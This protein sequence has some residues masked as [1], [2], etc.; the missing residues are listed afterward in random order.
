MGGRRRS[1]WAH[2]A[3]GDLRG[4]FRPRRQGLPAHHLAA[5][6]TVG[7]RPARPRRRDHPRLARPTDRFVDLTA[8]VADMPRAEIA[9]CSAGPTGRAVLAWRQRPGRA[10]AFTPGPGS[11]P[12]C[13]T[14][15]ST[16][17]PASSPP[18]GSTSGPGPTPPP[19]RSPPTSPNWKPARPLRPGRAAPP[20]P[21]PR[22][23]PLGGGCLPRRAPRRPPR[24]RRGRPPGREPRRGRRTGTPGAHRRTPGPRPK[25]NPPSRIVPL[26]SWRVARGFPRTRGHTRAP[27][28][29]GQL[30]RLGRQAPPDPCPWGAN[31]GCR[32]AGPRAAVRCSR[33]AG[34]RRAGRWAGG[35]P[36][37]R[38]GERTR[39][40]RCHCCFPF[41][42]GS[43]HNSVVHSI[44]RHRLGLAVCHL[45]WHA[46]PE[47]PA[48]LRAPPV[49]LRRTPAAH[50]A[51]G[52]VR[53]PVTS[54]SP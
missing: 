20:L 32:A 19:G 40:T 16:S 36:S 43:G 33:T 24:R 47:P 54:A 3:G 27:Y 22:L 23:L 8:A 12:I 45:E 49:V 5:R 38:Y 11:H 15:I 42:A 17:I 46:P 48:A 53:G 10:V 44:T 21:P 41:A 31:R 7:R 39:I 52:P 29:G 26:A 35:P 28:V 2:R 9:R 30:T 34:A 51:Q 4:A 14:R 25:L 6:G 13:A 1:P 50:R 37:C 18:A